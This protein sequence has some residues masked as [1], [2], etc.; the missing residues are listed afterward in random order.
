MSSIPNPYAPSPLAEPLPG[1]VNVRPIQLLRR[2]FE[3]I[4]GEYWL[5]LGITIVGILIASVVPFGLLLGPM[6]VGMFLC[7]AQRQRTGRTDFGTLF[8]GFDQF[9]DAF[10]AT[11]VMIALA[12]AIFLPLIAVFLIVLAMVAASAQ[13]GAQPDVALLSLLLAF[14]PLMMFA[15]IAIYVPFMFTFQLIAD[16]KVTAGVAV[17][18]SARAAWH[19]LGGVIWFLVA[20]GFITLLAA[21]PCYIPAILL[22]PLTVGA[23]WLFYQDVFGI[24]ETAPIESAPMQPV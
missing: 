6:M 17:K 11:L 10:I 12:M 23:L 16:R 9:M 4:Q 8:K 15:N 5:F 20:V 13:N 7:F 19:N 21:L 3:M 2:A 18:A 14:Y 22:L 24:I 1:R